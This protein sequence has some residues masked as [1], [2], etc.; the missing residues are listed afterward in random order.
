[1][2]P[3]NGPKTFNVFRQFRSE[4]S[5]SRN[6]QLPVTHGREIDAAPR[7]QLTYHV[8]RDV[9]CLT[10]VEGRPKRVATQ[11]RKFASKSKTG[12]EEVTCVI[13]FKGS[14]NRIFTD[15]SI[16]YC[17][18]CFIS[19]RNDFSLDLLLVRHR[20]DSKIS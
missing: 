3:I 20:T 4:N 11:R 14:Q 7:T 5:A 13:D 9:T 1:M 16:S 18:T 6:R 10:H 17:L 8:F 12:W 2:R 15:Y 19:Q